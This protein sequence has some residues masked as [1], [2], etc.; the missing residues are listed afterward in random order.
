M[1]AIAYKGKALGKPM[2]RQQAE[3]MIMRLQGALTGLKL[4]EVEG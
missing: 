3:A 2:G 4:V 1:W